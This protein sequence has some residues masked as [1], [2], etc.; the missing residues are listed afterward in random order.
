MVLEGGI[1]AALQRDFYQQAKTTDT[2]TFE[3]TDPVHKLEQAKLTLAAS[4]VSVDLAEKNLHA[5][6]RKHELGSETAFFFLHAQNQLV[7]AE[8]ARAQADINYQLALTALDHA[9]GELLKHRGLEIKI[10][11]IGRGHAP[12]THLTCANRSKIKPSKPW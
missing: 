5:E 12:V 1:L 3:V 2:V 11:D 7:Q 9:T 8:F 10:E 6:E 4:R